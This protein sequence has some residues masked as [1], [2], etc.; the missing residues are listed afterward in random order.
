MFKNNFKHSFRA[1]FRQKGYLIINIIGLS[2]GIAC[3]MIIALFIIHE[4]NYDRFNEKKDRIYRLVVN[5]KIGEREV[6]YAITSAPMGPTMLREFPEVEDFVRILPS[7]ESIVKYK[8]KSF[9]ENSFVSA[10]SSFFN[11]FSIPLIRGDKK[12][13]LNASHKLV[14]SETTAKKIFGQLDPMDKMLKIEDDTIPFVVSG[15]M[16]DVPENSHFNANMIGSFMTYNSG[17]DNW[18]DNNFITYILLL[19]NSKPEQV[20]AKIPAMISKYMGPAIKKYFGI[21]ME[22]FIAKNHYNIYLQPLKDI[23]LNPSITQYFTKNPANP[24]YLFIF[25]SIA[26]LIILIAAFNYMNLSTAQASKRA[27]EVGIKKLSGSSKGML[28]GQF[29]TESG[30]LSFLSL[31]IAII[32]VENSLPYFNRLLGSNLQLNLFNIW[33]TIPLLLFVS[34]LIGILAGSYPAFYLSSFTPYIVLKGKL[35]DS[36]K[37]GNLRKILVVFQF[38]ISIILIVGTLII[39]R[40][41]RFMLNKDLGFNKEQ[42]LVISRAE[43]IGNSVKSFKD[44]LIRI[45]GVMHVASSTAVPGRSESGTAY[46]AE[47]HPGDLFEFKINFIDYDFFSTYGIKFSSGRDFNPS[48]ATDP[49]ACIINERGVRQINVSNP[50]TSRLVSGDQKVPIIGVVK[51]FHFESLQN[52]INPYIFRFK[53]DNINYG[54][55]SLRLTNNAGS[56]TLN[57]IEKVWEKFAP[58][59]PIQYYFID[60]DFAQK[61]KE[62]KQNAQLSV[63]FTFLA[64]IIAA[65]GLF[66]LTSIALEQRTKEVGIR[67]SMGASATS[68]LYLLS[69]EFMLLVSVSTILAWPIIY[70]IAKN[71]LQNYYYRIALRPFD[72]LAG[73]IIALII[74]MITIGYRTIISARANPVDSLRYE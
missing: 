38:T 25:G 8:D 34:V 4:L 59:T 69:K 68:I 65:L 14:L 48:F 43:T 57:E 17:N 61:Y 19:P 6:S 29:L 12:T 58:G 37:N 28:I 18:N 13:V 41:I 42:L 2:I 11:V 1:L 72:F 44:A 55:I 23:H 10:D 31:I 27:K 7:R 30:L 33:F 70:L 49:G 64:I 24:K 52:E 71:W 45:P 74:A 53:N 21:T 26:F 39:F 50:L 35:K 36:M 51:D 40:Q 63:L 15:L 46:Y 66:G 54:Y 32:I 20:N 47:E 3:S 62:E 9:T 16:A 56:N 73:L 67:K 22:E 5:G 60:R